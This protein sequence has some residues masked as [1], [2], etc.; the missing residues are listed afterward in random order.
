MNGFFG[1]TQMKIKQ[2][3]RLTQSLWL[4]RS[5]T[6]CFW[7]WP[8]AAKSCVGMVNF[9]VMFLVCSHPD[10]QIGQ[11]GAGAHTIIVDREL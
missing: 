11:S 6:N 10:Y 3:R 8:G 7:F 5:E 1:L 4:S 9:A 2:S